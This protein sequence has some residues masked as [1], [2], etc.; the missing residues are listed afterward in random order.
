MRE[1]HGAGLGL[2]NKLRMALAIFFKNWAEIIAFILLIIGF[3]L[4]LAAPSAV[5]S[6]LIIFLGGMMAGRFVYYKKRRM[7]FPYVLITIGF[8][9]GYLI[10]SRYGNWLVI[11]ILFVLGSILSYYLHEQGYIKDIKLWP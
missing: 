11:T 9:I 2:R 10:G 1:R 8:F 3:L 6:Y 7:V 5:L 4:S